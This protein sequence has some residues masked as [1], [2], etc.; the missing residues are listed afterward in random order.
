MD[1]EALSDDNGVSSGDFAGS[2]QWIRV[3]GDGETDIDGATE[4]TY[5][6]RPDDIGKTLK[7]RIDFDDDAGYPESRTSDATPEVAGAPITGDFELHSANDQPPGRLGQQHHHLGGRR[8][9]PHALRV[10]TQQ[11]RPG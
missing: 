9:R 5:T 8:R 10:R 6:P 2:Y 11:R 1:V 3:D 7:V 4:A